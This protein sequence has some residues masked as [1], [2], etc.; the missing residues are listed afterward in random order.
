MTLPSSAGND[1]NAS[2][3]YS[4]GG[5]GEGR[6]FIRPVVAGRLFRTIPGKHDLLEFPAAV[7]ARPQPTFDFLNAVDHVTTILSTFGGRHVCCGS[8]PPN[9]SVPT[10]PRS[11]RCRMPP[12]QRSASCWSHRKVCA[13]DYSKSG[14]QSQNSSGSGVRSS[15][16]HGSWSDW[17]RLLVGEAVCL[18]FWGSSEG[19]RVL[20]RTGFWRTGMG[21]RCLP[22][23]EHRWRDGERA[24]RS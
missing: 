7:L 2:E 10:I 1:P 19:S 22:L 13:Q 12:R 6:D 9:G 15:A 5:V 23:G 4:A 8:L 16:R 20:F 17:Q 11:G 18:A 14:R 24:R 3:H 21:V